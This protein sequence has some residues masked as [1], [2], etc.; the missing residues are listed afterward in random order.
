MAAVTAVLIERETGGNMADVLERIAN[1]IRQRFCFQRSAR[2]LTRRDVARLVAAIAPFVLAAFI[3]AANP[4][5][6]IV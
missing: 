6:V 1:L 5:W 3:E 4:G 2:T